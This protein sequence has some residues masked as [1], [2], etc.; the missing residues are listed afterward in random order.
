MDILFIDT[1]AGDRCFRNR[2]VFRQFYA[3][4]SKTNEWSK[5]DKSPIA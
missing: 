1:K 3:T 5:V 2:N 4:T